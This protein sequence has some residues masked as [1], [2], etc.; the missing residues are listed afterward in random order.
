[1]LNTKEVK[2]LGNSGDF[3]NKSVQ[4]IFLSHAAEI[5]H[6]MKNGVL[7]SSMV[8]FKKKLRQK[9]PTLN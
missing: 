1:M 9:H 3:S 8:L 7:R 4:I 2:A 6:G 5:K